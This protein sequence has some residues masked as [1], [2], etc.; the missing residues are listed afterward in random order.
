MTSSTEALPAQELNLQEP[1]SERQTPERQKPTGS[2]LSTLAQLALLSGLAV[3]LNALPV[4]LFFGIQVMLGSAPAIFALLLWPRWW[5][6]AIGVL[7]SLQTWPLWGHPWAVL[8]FTLELVWLW[9]WLRRASAARDARG[10]GEVLLLAIGYWLLIGAPLVFAF[11][12]LVMRIDPA[13][14]LVVAVKQSFNGVLNAELAFAALIITRALQARR[15][16]G[17]GL[18][19]RGVIIA[20][21]LLAHTLPNLLISIPAGH[22]LQR[23]V[24]QGVLDGLKTVSLAVSRAG[25]GEQTNQ[26]LIEQLGGDLAYRRIATDG[27]TTSSDPELFQ[28]LDGTFS[29][30]GRSQI[31]NSEL[32]LL[33][34]KGKGPV[35]H[36]WVNGY[37]SFSSQSTSPNGTALVQVVVPAGSA[38]TRMQAQ[39]SQLLAVSLG[40]VVLGAL[41][42]ALVG[43]QFEG[44][45]NRVVHPLQG[46][47]AASLVGGYPP[48]LQLSAVSELR[49]LAR[50]LN[51][52]ILE[53]NQLYRQLQD[54]NA[55]LLQSRQELESLLTTDPLTGCGN[56]QAL[57]ARLQEERH[58]SRRS[59][60]P[61]SCLWFALDG[62]GRAY[63]EF[64][65][66]LGDALLKGAAQALR[67][68]LRIT[69]H[70]FLSS[71]REFVVIATGCNAADAHDL[72]ANLLAA[73]D[74]IWIRP[75]GDRASDGPSCDLD[76]RG[77]PELTAQPRL[78]IASLDPQRDSVDSLMQR[79]RE[80]LAATQL[81]GS[82]LTSSVRAASAAEPS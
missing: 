27:G 14:V 44:E 29:D 56:R 4:P 43:R 39:T 77:D 64:G 78:G 50:Q 5:G 53:S 12:G 3:L 19:L 58:R 51:Q 59:G 7:A 36:K 69:D 35:L 16:L 42:S 80:S 37:W 6:V 41:L 68:R 61:L 82:L 49:T 67:E 62:V 11:Y 76:N 70:I 38:V 79:A 9:L 33:V 28:R 23:A 18:S 45:F 60:E 10:N 24:E 74:G 31:S 20:L 21:A 81:P 25:T 1:N 47:P 55:H 8:I 32:A 57:E 48:P 40:V 75:Q 2:R 54:R 65:S 73:I 72:G 66:Q 13:N 22:Q 30:G 52:R 17:P 46:K 15:N 71:E 26:L 34:P 63:N